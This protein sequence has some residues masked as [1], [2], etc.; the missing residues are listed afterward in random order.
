MHIRD[1]EKS[2]LVFMFL[3]DARHERSGGWENLVD[4]DEDGFFRRELNALA[5]DVDELPDSQ[6]SGHKVFLLIDGG[7]VGFLDLFA[8][9][10]GL[11]CQCDH[12]HEI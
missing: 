3:I 7:N 4:E 8:D 9:D 11:R 1:I 5:D 6:I 2:V 12:E 10:L